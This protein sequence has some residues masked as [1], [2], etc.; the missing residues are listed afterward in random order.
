MNRKTIT[1]ETDY[2]TVVVLYENDIKVGEVDVTDKSIHWT[3]SVIENWEVG[4]LNI[5]ESDDNEP[6]KIGTSSTNDSSI[7]SAG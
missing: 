2:S 1:R 6:N 5:I 4:I 3:E 7:A